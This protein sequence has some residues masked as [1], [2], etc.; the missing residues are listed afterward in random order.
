MKENWVKKM[1]QK[2]EGHQM[3]PP[4]GLWESIMQQMEAPSKP[5]RK[6]AAIWLRY[7]AA[8]MALLIVGFF[9]VYD[10]SNDGSDTNDSFLAEKVIKEE[11]SAENEK[12]DI[13]LLPEE[14]AL[15]K[16]LIAAR[17][18]LDNIEESSSEPVTEDASMVPHQQTR[19]QDEQQMVTQHEQQTMPQREQQVSEPANHYPSATKASRKRAVGKWSL[20]VNTSGGL[21][22]LGQPV[23][24]YSNVYISYMTA[25]QGTTDNSAYS[26]SI[27]R[28]ER[29][30]LMTHHPP[31]RLAL[32]LD[33]QLNRNVA[34]FSGINYSF[35]HSEYVIP[36]ENLVLNNQRLN[37]L[38]LP[39]GLSWKLWSTT[40]LS[41]YLSGETMIEKCLNREPWQ[42]SVQASAGVEYAFTRHLGIYL[43]PS[44]GY[45]FDDGSSLKHY[46]KEH[47]LSPSI[48][49][50]I[51]LHLAR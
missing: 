21:L 33:Y 35:F 5:V 1:R 15:P 23:N 43:N 3:A 50:G 37:Y 46:Y 25:F 48:E 9:A 30:S 31:V 22:A 40:H 6:P 2:L 27:I 16:P 51:R 13:Q 11:L 47:P 24:N 42:W 12:Y 20:G 44:L 34:L 45:Y 17:N 29:V 8:A 10:S 18:E 14:K 32:S 7:L 28:S 49:L 36:Q 26:R 4:P 39:L 41:F 19:T 38:G